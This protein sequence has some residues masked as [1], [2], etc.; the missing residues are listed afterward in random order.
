MV[1]LLVMAGC[2]KSDADENEPI[3]FADG[4][5]DSNKFYNEVASIIIEEG[6]GYET[7]DMTG[8]TAAIMTSIEKEEIDVH[9][10]IWS[11]NVK[12]IYDKGLEEGYYNT[13]SV[14][15]D[16]NF[17]GLY[18]PT[19]VIEGDAE[20]GIEPVAP[21]L[22]YMTDLP[23]YWELFKDPEDDGKGV[24]IG[25]ISGWTVDEV[26]RD[27]YEEYGLDE[28]YNY[29]SPGSESSINISLA[30]AYE[31]GEPW[32]GYNYEPNWVMAKYDMTPILE[33]VDDGPLASIGAQNVDIITH[34]GLSERVP[35]VVEFLE[36]F[37]TSSDV[38]NNALVYIQE[39]DA[40]AY[41]AAVKFLQEEKDL[42]TDWVP[43]DVAEKVE[44]SIQ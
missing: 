13:L 4:G 40:S 33:E 3:I 24:I 2:T 25:S 30:D 10:E 12:D 20:R 32:L 14:N 1:I 35:E 19:Y 36:N 27:G 23:E 42:W 21:N 11:E 39:E 9:M 8:S 16:D 15:F 43:T 5:W 38:A 17:Q 28:Y 34:P 31:N 26:L 29:I 41:D 37:Q 7:D 44:E 6:Y 22:K 18:V